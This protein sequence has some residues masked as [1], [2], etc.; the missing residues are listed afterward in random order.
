MAENI[1]GLYLDPRLM[2]AELSEQ[3]K[4][5]RDLFVQ[6]YIKD[7]DPFQAC[8]RVGFQAA[9]AIEYAKRFMSEAYVQRKIT[10]LQRIT[11]ENEAEQARQDK[12]LVLSVLRQ[13]AQNGPYASRVQAAAKLATILGL[14]RPGNGDEGGQVIINALRDFAA[15]APV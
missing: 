10:D 2:E 6:E 5:L 1:S 14:D 3:E 13:A 11:P 12:A 4:A 7:F 8:L 9:F 15:R